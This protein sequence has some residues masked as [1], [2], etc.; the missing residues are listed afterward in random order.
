MLHSIDH[1][2]PRNNPSVQQSM[3]AK[4]EFHL[5]KFKRILMDH[6][7]FQQFVMIYCPQPIC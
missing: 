7:T 4:C 3:N 5:K 6:K 1:D 2:Y